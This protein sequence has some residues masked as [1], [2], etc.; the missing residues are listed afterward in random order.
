MGGDQQARVAALTA[1]G[2]GRDVQGLFI[3]ADRETGAVQAGARAEAPAM[4]PV[5]T[6]STRHS[7]AEYPFTTAHS[8]QVNHAPIW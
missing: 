7:R 5:T 3:A 2:D 6:S 4:R 1:P 8:R